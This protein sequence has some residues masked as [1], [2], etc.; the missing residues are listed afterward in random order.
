MRC[1]TNADSGGGGGIAVRECEAPEQCRH[2]ECLGAPVTATTAALAMGA[3]AA[4][5]EER[6]WWQKMRARPQIIAVSIGANRGRRRC[7]RR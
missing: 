1:I 5:R 7:R 3:A 2:G 6:I 4:R